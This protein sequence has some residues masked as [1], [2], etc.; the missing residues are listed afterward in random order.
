MLLTWLL[1]CADTEENKDKIPDTESIDTSVPEEIPDTA[2]QPEPEEEEEEETEPNE[3]QNERPVTIEDIQKGLYEVGQTVTLKDVVVSSPSNHYGFYITTANGGP[4]SGLFVY[5]YFNNAVSLNIEQGDILTITGEVWEYPDTCDD[6]MDND[7]DLL[8][9]SDDPDCL[10]GGQEEVLSE[11]QTMTEIKLLNPNDIIKTGELDTDLPITIVDSA[12]L[13]DPLQAEEYEGVL[14]RME[15]VTVTSE[16]NADGRWSVDN[17]WIDDVFGIEPGLVNVGDGFAYVQGI[18]H[19]SSGKYK[20]VPRH[21]SDLNGWIKTCDG[22]KCIWDASPDELVITEFM[23]NPDNDGSCSDSDGEYVEVTYMTSSSD[24]LDIRGLFLS[25]TSTTEQI[26]EHAVLEPNE[27]AWISVGQQSC[28][29]NASVLLGSTGFSLNNTGDDI[30]L[31]YVEESGTIINFDQ[32]SYTGSWVEVGVASQLD[33]NSHNTTDN[34]IAENWCLAT[35]PIEGTL[36][37]GTPG[38]ENQ[39]CP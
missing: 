10:N 23:A 17:V 8:V 26:K 19:F 3:D 37:F 20:L 31:S 34:D 36:D 12:I 29:G 21:D 18:L 27:R 2:S 32:L 9:D 7:G 5:Y 35:T 33:P 28:Y 22:D 14:L 11:F 24:S 4:F 13:A 39:E 30:V 38:E 15:D 25:D 16:V 6:N 1:A